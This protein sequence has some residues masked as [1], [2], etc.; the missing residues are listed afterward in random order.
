MTTRMDSSDMSNE[1]NPAPGPSNGA[2]ARLPCRCP[3]ISLS[4]SLPIGVEGATIAVPK[5][6]KDGEPSAAASITLDGREIWDGAKLVG[7]I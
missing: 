4:V 1:T 3:P 2:M 5:R 6:T 7:R